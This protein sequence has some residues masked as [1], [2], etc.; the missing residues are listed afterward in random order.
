MKNFVTSTLLFISF[1]G[2]TQNEIL[3]HPEFKKAQ[4]Y[5]STG[6]YSKAISTLEK[7]RLTTSKKESIFIINSNLILFY[8]TNNDFIKGKFIIE[9]N[10]NYLEKNVEEIDSNYICDFYQKK[11]TY[12]FYQMK[13]DTS[14]L[15]INK[16]LKYATKTIDTVYCFYSISD[17][18]RK[19]GE[20]DSSFFLLKKCLELSTNKVF[21]E[22]ILGD[23]HYKLSYIYR[24][25]KNDSK[26]GEYHFFKSVQYHKELSPVRV[27]GYYGEYGQYLSNQ[28]NTAEGLKYTLKSLDFFSENISNKKHNAFGITYSILASM[29]FVQDDYEKALT[30]LEM[31]SK[32][33]IDPFYKERNNIK[34]GYILGYINNKKEAISIFQ[35]SISNLKKYNLNLYQ[36]EIANLCNPSIDWLSL[37]DINSII[38]IDSLVENYQGENF[39]ILFEWQR[40]N[41][42]FKNYNNANE[43]SNKILAIDIDEI[44]YVNNIVTSQPNS[45]IIKRALI[46]KSIALLY[47]DK[48]E[49]S[50][51]LFKATQINFSNIN[52]GST[53][54][55]STNYLYEFSRLDIYKDKLLELLEL[56][57]NKKMKLHLNESQAKD[58]AFI[59]KE[60]ETKESE[61]KEKLNLKIQDLQFS[62]NSE[63]KNELNSEISILKAELKGIE[64][65]IEIANPKF[66]NLKYKNTSI[67]KANI[68][69]LLLL[70]QGTLEYYRTDSNLFVFTITNSN[71]HVEQTKIDS[72]FTQN[73]ALF[74]K[75]TSDYTYITQ[76]PQKAWEEYTSSAT[77]LYDKLFPEKV[78]EL[79]KG[80]NH[81]YIIP[82]GELNT[83]S[84]EA[85]LK[86]KPKTKERDYKKLAY[87]IN[88]FDISYAYSAT[89]LFKTKDFRTPTKEKLLTYGGFAPE[90]DKN[91]LAKAEELEN[92]RNFRS[93]PTALTNNKSEIN[94]IAKLFNGDEY[95]S[96]QANEKN[97]KENAGKYKILHLAMHAL[98]DD[99]DPL[100]SKFLFT[101]TKND[102][103]EDNYL[104]AYELYNMELNADLAVLS[105][106]NTGYGKI[107]RGEGAMSLAR[108]FKYAG[109]PSVVMS[110]WQ[111]DDEATSTL[112][113]DF[114]KNLKQS[115]TKSVSL[116][117]A[118]LNYLK[119]AD[120]ITSH[121]YF[122]SNF[123]VLGD[124]TPVENGNDYK[125]L[126]WLLGFIGIGGIILLTYRKKLT[127]KTA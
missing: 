70:E 124:N 108:A 25:T 62:E 89:L 5:S 20:I 11:G 64:N 80:K 10:H 104:N 61:T 109:C 47:L 111:A 49:Y 78:R 79:L 48:V 63:R 98:T 72:T 69:N 6:N 12:Y 45:S 117:D 118:K 53:S 52:D 112:M 37:N 26:N 94:S 33:N 43:I 39:R 32:T 3:E 101:N 17:N 4:N 123:V 120:N 24:Y 42:K 103:T 58:F 68:Q 87:L 74:R 99:E 100:Y 85:L 96:L 57:K 91:L 114:F 125:W 82:D 126:W 95:F 90:Y 44:K 22:K 77:Y 76:N 105:A 19:I 16:A 38:N 54:I 35:K 56:E 2:L 15:N 18:L 14:T 110:L 92:F 106:C 40:K 65:E 41:L 46:N 27:A 9:N 97:F 28:G 122:W 21:D 51:K 23:I 7:L 34:K 8:S 55:E 83:I 88:D 119:Q 29:Y 102:S 127:K 116:R 66:Y 31:A 13:Y 50:Y 93:N 67:T 81:I 71:Y 84:F 121:P 113:V 86:E 30:Y 60:I 115:N 1:W 75:T 107:E 36:F 73:L 59:P